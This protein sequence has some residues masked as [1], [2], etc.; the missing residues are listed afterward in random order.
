MASSL[1]VVTL[2]V[3]SLAEVWWI[4]KIQPYRQEMLKPL[5]AGAAAAVVGLLLMH[6][7]RAGSAGASSLADFV[8]A[9]VLVSAFMAVYAL[10]LYWLGLTDEDR[11]V[12]HAVRAKFLRA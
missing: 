4:L 6:A 1:T 3:V 10:A 11:Q 8:A 5:I 2:N 12:F 9:S 7:T